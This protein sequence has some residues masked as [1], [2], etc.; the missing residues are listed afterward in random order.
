[1]IHLLTQSDQNSLIALLQIYTKLRNNSHHVA[2][3]AIS[4]Y[5]S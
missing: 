5:G 3:V 4:L 2:E 1:M